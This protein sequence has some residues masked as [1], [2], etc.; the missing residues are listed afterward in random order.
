MLDI[1]F[2]TPY[3]LTQRGT[4][5]VYLFVFVRINNTSVDTLEE[6]QDDKGKII[7]REIAELGGE[8]EANKSGAITDPILGPPA[9]EPVR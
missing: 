7:T 6:M 9:V 8:T 3:Q 2:T 4:F 5:F 1:G